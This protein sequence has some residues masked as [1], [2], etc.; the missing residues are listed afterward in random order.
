MKVAL[1]RRY[2]IWM[3]ALLPATLGIGTA[4]LWA[5]S[6]NWPCDIDREGLMLRCRRKIHWRVIRQVTVVRDYLDGHVAR[7]DIDCP[8]GISRIP[9]HALYDGEHIAAV[10]LAMF[11]KSRR[12]Q[13]HQLRA[14]RDVA[15]TGAPALQPELA[16]E[17]A[18]AF[19]RKS[20][21]NSRTDDGSG[22]RIL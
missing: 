21:Y 12:Q 9:V 17:S 22:I 15:S 1:A 3:L 16:S 13:L 5:R 20:P 4:A 2:R 11:K 10:I 7:I 14:S 18:D 8:G 6:L 19:G